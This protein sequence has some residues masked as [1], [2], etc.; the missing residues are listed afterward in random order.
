MTE[1]TPQVDKSHYGARYRGKDRWLSYFYQL[2]LVRAL[3]PES[4]LEIGPGEGIVTDTLR[5]DGVKVTTCDIAADLQPDVVASVTALPFN[6]NEFEVLLAA[7]I[8]EHIKFEDVSQALSELERVARTHVVIS[9]PH[10][11]WVFSC[12]VK[13]PLIPR[14]GVLF[15]IPFF[16][17]EHHFNGEHYWELGKRGYSVRRFVDCAKAQGLILDRS[18]KYSDDPVHRL[19][20]FSKKHI[21]TN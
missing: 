21:M 5:K 15:Q 17:K 8:L 2:A 10:P 19:F 6:D 12:E 13:L 1:Y 18:V 7:E 9:L 3:S 11:G 16:W 14:F 4:V 20:V